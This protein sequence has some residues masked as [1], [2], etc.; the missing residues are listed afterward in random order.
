MENL[1][2]TFATFQTIL[3]R[4]N[5]TKLHDASS[6]EPGWLHNRSETS[7]NLTNWQREG[8]QLLDHKWLAPFLQVTNPVLLYVIYSYLYTFQSTLIIKY[9]PYFSQTRDDING[10]FL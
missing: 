5:K 6:G 1:N 10:T 7:G 8:R 2:K 4:E 3:G 9:K